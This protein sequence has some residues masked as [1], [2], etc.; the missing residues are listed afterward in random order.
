[1]YSRVVVGR[2]DVG[3]ESFGRSERCEFWLVQRRHLE[4]ASQIRR[5]QP[6]SFYFATNA[7]G[8][9]RFVAGEQRLDASRRVNPC[10]VRAGCQVHEA[11]EHTLIEE[12]QV[13][14][15]NNDD[16]GAGPRQ[17]GQHAADGA[18]A[19]NDVGVHGHAEIRESIGVIGDDNHPV[20]DSPEDL[21]L[22]YDDG[23]AADDEAALVATTEP[24]GLSAGDDGGGNGRRGHGL[25]MT[26]AQLGRLL[27]ACLH[28]AIADVLPQRLEF[29]EEWLN[30]DGLRDGSIGL[31][32]LSA[33]TGFLR[34]EGL[35]YEDVMARAGALAAQWSSATLPPYQRR[36]AGS[37]P[38]GLRCRFALRVASRIVRGVLSTSSAA[39]RVRRGHATMK[40]N[41]S[42]F[43]G[44]R[45]RQPAP[46][47]AFYRALAVETL[48]IFQIAA[49]A[50]I[51]S[52]RAVSG[53]ACV[54]AIEIVSQGHADQPAIAA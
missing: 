36:L 16:V 17:G 10:A 19:W 20:G 5:A 52:C 21:E 54:I 11:P 18:G 22:P 25:I 49:R 27:P 51:E 9:E 47:C 53:S 38:A 42:V 35:A 1:M 41:A 30:P 43:C 45:D 50:Q 32:P 37:L 15:D 26:E 44:V 48:K 39:T 14:G 31:A 6:S 24:A 12:R 4:D 13:A 2:I 8:R 23:V 34:T 40:V 3:Q 28:Q 46:L 33:V 7:I 29:Y